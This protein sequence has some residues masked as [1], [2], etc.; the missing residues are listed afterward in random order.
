MGFPSMSAYDID[1]LFDSIMKEHA[2]EKNIFSFYMD[3]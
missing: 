2:L 3:S 1:P